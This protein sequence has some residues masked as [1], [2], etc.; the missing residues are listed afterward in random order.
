[1]SCKKGKPVGTLRLS[2]A[3][4]HTH[5]C[6]KRLH[7]VAHIWETH[8]HTTAHIRRREGDGNEPQLGEM[9]DNM[10]VGILSL[11]KV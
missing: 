5:T 4:K 8:A 7:A 3:S 11:Y 2:D 9:R 1:M 6:R 10:Q